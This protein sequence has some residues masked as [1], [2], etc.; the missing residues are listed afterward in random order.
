M[1]D[2]DSVQNLNY[3]TGVYAWIN[4]VNQKIYIGGAY[5]SFS[6]RH[7][8]Y[9]QRLNRNACH[10]RHLQSAWNK[11]GSDS[12]E[13]CLVERCHPEDVAEW[14]T[15]WIAFFDSTN[16]KQGYNFCRSGCSR[17]GVKHTV[18]ARQKISATKKA[19]YKIQ[20]GPRTGAVL[21]AA[22]KAKISASKKGSKLSAATKAKMS[23][24]RKGRK[25][26]PEHIANSAANHWSKG[27]RAKEIAAKIA[28][29]NIG[30]KRSD[31]TRQ[32]ISASKLDPSDA[33]RAK[34]SKSGKEYWAKRRATQ[35][36]TT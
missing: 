30:T 20:P 3:N 32:M 15:Y 25:Q 1:I 7:K 9:I 29:K 31:Q 5:D 16:Q 10:N 2:F 35:Q 24:V 12:F 21:S 11:Y 17:L 8:D 34:L 28:A 36:N 19:K 26:S 27:P 4:T 18:K 22:T 6:N 33:T 14:E 13:W 23:A